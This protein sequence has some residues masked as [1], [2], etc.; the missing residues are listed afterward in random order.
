[1]PAARFETRRINVRPPTLH[2]VVADDCIFAVAIIAAAAA[3]AAVAIHL[4]TLTI[5]AAV[6]AAAVG[7]HSLTLAIAAAVV[8]AVAIDSPTLQSL[9]H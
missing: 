6:V 3:A 7:I 1:M 5:A 8:A 4:L 9:P 2:N